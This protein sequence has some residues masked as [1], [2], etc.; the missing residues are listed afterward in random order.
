MNTKS[1]LRNLMILI[2]PMNRHQ[3]YSGDYDSRLYNREYKYSALLDSTTKISLIFIQFTLRLHVCAYSHELVVL[4]YSR[5]SVILHCSVLS[6][7]RADSWALS[8]QT[9]FL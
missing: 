2:K 4:S 8:L 7:Y 9:T 3:L 1:A 6:E 5:F